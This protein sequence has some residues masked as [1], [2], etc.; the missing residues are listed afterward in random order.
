MDA[1]EERSH[2][3]RQAIAAEEQS[4]KET[5]VTYTRHVNNYQLWWDASQARLLLDDP[6]HTVIPAL[7][8]IPSKVTL[9]LEY[10]TT[11]PQV[12]R[13]TSAIFQALISYDRSENAKMVRR[14]QVQSVS[15]E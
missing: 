8:I 6:F 3:I 15:P 10:E 12:I 2:A 7:P 9:F 5:G 13:F 4:D 14:P 1:L 11:R